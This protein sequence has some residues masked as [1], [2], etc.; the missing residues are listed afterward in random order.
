MP[1]WPRWLVALVDTIMA[2]ELAEIEFSG[3]GYRWIMRK[4]P[5]QQSL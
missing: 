4:H 1:S 3:S 2:N 5:L